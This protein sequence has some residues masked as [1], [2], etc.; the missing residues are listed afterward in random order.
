MLI[1]PG[2]LDV[3][4]LVLVS[5]LLQ[6]ISGPLAVESSAKMK[7]YRRFSLFGPF[8]T[9]GHNPTLLPALALA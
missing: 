9:P 7:L 5:R 1:M 8:Q 4:V 6:R 3:M 2:V